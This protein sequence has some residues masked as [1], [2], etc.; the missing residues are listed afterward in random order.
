MSTK[1]IFPSQHL[2]NLPV[3]PTKYYLVE[4]RIHGA[5]PFYAGNFV[6]LTLWSAPSSSCRILLSSV[7]VIADFAQVHVYFF[8]FD[9]VSLG[10][11]K[12]VSKG[13][14]GSWCWALLLL[15]SDDG[16]TLSGCHL[17]CMLYPKYTIQD[18]LG[19]LKT[20]PDS[21]ALP[22]QA[23]PSRMTKFFCHKMKN[24]KKKKIFLHVHVF[25]YF[26]ACILRCKWR[27]P[28]AVQAML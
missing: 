28:V 21:Q 17:F 14:S 4:W 16:I 18:Y 1:S 24:K 12:Q 22:H 19:C 23:K 26:L 11:E 9:C 13:L 27:P 25:V 10:L 15:P 5:W 8:E 7:F 6:I 3:I 20:L 2:C